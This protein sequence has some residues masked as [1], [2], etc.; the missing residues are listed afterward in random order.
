VQ[1]QDEARAA[2]TAAIN[3][4]KVVSCTTI[5]AHDGSQLGPEARGTVTNNSSKRSSYVIG[6]VF[7][8][9]AG[10]QIDARTVGVNNVDPG[11]QASWV[12]NPVP[13][14]ADASG[15]KCRIADLRRYVARLD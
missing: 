13:T 14:R 1:R 2:R 3:D 9:A 15:A 4:V 6:L 11:Q 8:D 7:E 12:S 5:E 10:R